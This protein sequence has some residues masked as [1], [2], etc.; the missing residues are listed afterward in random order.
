MNRKKSNVHFY[1]NKMAHKE[2]AQRKIE[3]NAKL[4]LC[5]AVNTNINL[6]TLSYKIFKIWAHGWNRN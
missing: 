3:F 1:I 2:C 4:N 6:I 5:S